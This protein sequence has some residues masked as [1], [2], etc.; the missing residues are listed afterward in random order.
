MFEKDDVK[1]HQETNPTI[2]QLEVGEKL[3]MVNS[4]QSLDSFNLYNNSIFNPKIGSVAGIKLRA[5]IKNR[6]QLLPFN[7]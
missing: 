7:Q 2:R 6:Y 5:I 1:V 3:S 4:I